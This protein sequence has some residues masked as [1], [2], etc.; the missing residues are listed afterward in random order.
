[1]LIQYTSPILKQSSYH[2]LGGMGS[3]GLETG[4]RWRAEQEINTLVGFIFSIL[5]HWLICLFL[6]RCHT[7]LITIACGYVL[8]FGKARFHLIINLLKIFIVIDIQ[9]FPLSE[10]WN[11][12]VKFY[13]NNPTSILLGMTFN[14]GVI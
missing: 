6:L 2:Q 14:F 1:M 5:F 7:V 12:C 4:I 9:V 11:Q 3:F 13:L 8:V 10:L